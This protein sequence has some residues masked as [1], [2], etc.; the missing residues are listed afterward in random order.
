MQCIFF[1]GE[2]KVCVASVRSFWKVDEATLKKYCQ[3]ESFAACP[4]YM[5]NMHYQ[6]ASSNLKLKSK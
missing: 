6:E 5:A 4:R 1:E 3:T 2:E